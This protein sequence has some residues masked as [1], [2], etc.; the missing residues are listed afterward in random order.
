MR[1]TFY[2]VKD[3]Q[4]LAHEPLLER[5]RDFKAFMKKVKRAFHKDQKHTVERLYENRPVYT[6]D[7]I[8]RERYAVCCNGVCME[9][10][11]CN[12]SFSQLIVA[13]EVRQRSRNRTYL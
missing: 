6:V 4:F 7:H 10:S 3:I 8:V 1:R 13:A 2:Y 9:E 5:F 11:Y 12:S